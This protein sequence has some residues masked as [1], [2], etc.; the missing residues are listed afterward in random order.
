M[1][2]IIKQKISKK[3]KEYLKNH[4]NEHPW[5]K[6]DKF[7]SKP[8]EHLKEILR[9]DFNFEEEYTDIRW[10]HN[11]SVDIAFLDKKLAI[12]VNGNQHYNN[13]GT[14]A[15][16]FQKR[17][18]YLLSEGWTILEIHYAACYKND[19]IDELKDAIINCKNI[20]LEKHKLLF[21]NRQKTKK[22]K[23]LIKIQNYS[24]AKENDL[25][26]SSGRINGKKYKL[27]DL[28]KYKSIILSSNVNLMDKHFRK[29]LKDA[30]NLSLNII[31][32][33][34]KYFN[35]KHY[36]LNKNRIKQKYI[37]KYNWDNIDR[38][39]YNKIIN[40]GIDLTKFGWIEKVANKT[41]LTRRQIYRLV[42]KTELK[43]IVYRRNNKKTI[44]Q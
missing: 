44:S 4:P 30:T 20:D 33:V 36:I 39:N 17:H 41:G 8:C 23:E 10:K 32:Y 42:N 16:Y 35:I 31:N 34:L 22:E 2:D 15:E 43:E 27:L 28:K 21:E 3:R 38:N 5:K 1:N 9:K 13:D 7:K 12:E 26:D 25:L 18:D 24:Y 19:K 37:K 6:S 14:L 11:Y 29:K 40:S